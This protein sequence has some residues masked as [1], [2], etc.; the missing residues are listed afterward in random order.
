MYS[1]LPDATIWTL[2]LPASLVLILLLST[3]GLPFLSLAGQTL[4][5][6]HRRSFYDKCGKQMA[7]LCALIAPLVL[8]ISIAITV[9]SIQL[10]PLLVES[11]LRLP[12]I[13]LLAAMAGS[14]IFSVL[15]FLLWKR[16][17]KTL[18]LVHQFLGLA[19][20]VGML[21]TLFIA[22]ALARVIMLPGHPL[23][24]TAPPIELMKAFLMPPIT[25]MLWSLSLL[26]LC[27]VIAIAGAMA[28]FWL[29]LRRDADNFGRDYYAF[30]MPWCARWSLV[31]AIMTLAPLGYNLWIVLQAPLT[32]TIPMPPLLPL[33][34]SILAPL[35]AI[36]CSGLI[37]KSQTPM[38]YKG[39]ASSL[40]FFYFFGITGLL[41]T[42]ITVTQQT[43]KVVQ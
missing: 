22:S 19:A 6:A 27:G 15:Y 38:R 2:A 3:A 39:C 25:S 18:P 16:L 8:C 17:A 41:A 36:T 13:T 23:P 14:S 31:G 20:S 11:P 29:V 26:A 1:I 32:G 28:M 5:K 43:L 37:S 34:L 35:V 10:D 7:M 40:V 33:G 21:T 24:A 9:R 4:A 42:L 12:I 30:V